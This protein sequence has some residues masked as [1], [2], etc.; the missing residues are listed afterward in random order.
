[1][2]LRKEVELVCYRRGD[3]YYFCHGVHF[4]TGI[5]SKAF[6]GKSFIEIKEQIY[7]D[8]EKKMADIK[9]I[10]NG[11]AIIAA[12]YI[13]TVLSDGE[14]KSHEGVVA[15]CRCGKSEDGIFCNGAHA[16]KDE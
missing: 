15:L 5:T 4:P 8:L 12:K 2:S 1:M 16:K 13:T 3:G 6:D 7:Q 11:P 9:I 14:K 10:E